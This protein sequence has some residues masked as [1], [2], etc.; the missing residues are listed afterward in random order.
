MLADILRRSRT[1]APGRDLPERYGPWRTCYDRFVRWPYRGSSTGRYPHDGRAS[2]GTVYH[3]RVGGGRREKDRRGCDV[4]EWSSSDITANGITIH[5]YRTGGDKPPVVLNHG[6]T[7]DGLC[8]TRLARALEGEYD[9]IMPDARG[10]GR[11][12]AP[13]GGYDSAT[14]AADLAAFIQALGL[15]RPA[16]GGHSMGAMTAFFLAATYPDRLRCA[17]LEDP[18]FRLETGTPPEAEQRARAER[19][20]REREE[21]RSLGR[22]G[23]IA[24]VRAARPDWA[25]EEYGPWADAQLRVRTPPGGAPRPAEQGAWRDLVP[26]LACPTLLVTADPDQGSIVTPEAA[27]EA[28]RLNP[29]VRVVRLRGAGHNIRR[30]QFDGYVAAVRAFLASI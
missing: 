28:A 19:T 25:E 2:A 18:G 8:W 14:R 10:H 12:E 15:V 27:A 1:G 21:R 5:Y 3:H 16:V 7:D 29:L 23:L 4:A 11:S 13:D 22:E 20:R 6:A 26:K 24:W 30:E 9:V 17:I